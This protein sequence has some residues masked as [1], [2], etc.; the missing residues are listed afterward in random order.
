[1]P[2]D[3]TVIACRFVSDALMADIAKLVGP[4]LPKLDVYPGSIVG[5]C[6]SCGREVW[7]GPRQQDLVKAQPTAEVMCM[8]C[9]AFLNRRWWKTMVEDDE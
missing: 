8:L 4:E 3:R 1:M 6:S 2:F 7:I 5:K 9:A